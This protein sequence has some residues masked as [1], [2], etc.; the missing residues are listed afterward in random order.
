MD[1][2]ETTPAPKR[3][4]IAGRVLALALILYC[5]AIAVVYRQRADAFAAVTVCPP[6]AWSLP[7][8]LVLLA[9]STRRAGGRLLG[10]AWLAWLIFL[11]ATAD[12]PLAITRQ[13]PSPA[14]A[15][16]EPTTGKIPI[17]IISLNCGNLN[18]RSAEDVI[19][20][21]PDVVLLQESPGPR[22]VADLARKLYGERG[23]FLWNADASIVADGGV[24]PLPGHDP[25]N[26]HASA[27]I[28]ELAAGAKI[29]VV[30][31]R[32]EPA[33]VRL[34]FWSPACWREQTENRQLRRRQLR[35]MVENHAAVPADV[36]LVF[37]GDFNAPAGDAVF[38]E[39][40]PRLRDPFRDVGAG[41]GNTIVNEFPFARIDQIW[42]DDHWQAAVVQAQ[43]TRRSDHRMVIADLLV[44][45]PA[46]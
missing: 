7:A 13:A 46:N 24:E 26:I 33:I 23:Q 20:Y 6:W 43:R 37:G 19:A 1:E 11:P 40:E 36:P 30:S 45:R 16:A 2:P 22:E 32:L 8:F 9:A 42:I 39:L 44:E 38:R 12:T 5:I 18:G 17:R 21:H 28:V 3:P 29:A 27:A 25:K 4:S 14:A 35:T 34:D 15:P 41:W 10:L 31:M